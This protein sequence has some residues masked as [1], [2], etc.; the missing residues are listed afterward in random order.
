MPTQVKMKAERVQWVREN[1]RPANPLCSCGCGKKTK[2]GR[3]V[4]GHDAQLRSELETI[5]E[6]GG[7]SARPARE[8]LKRFGW[9]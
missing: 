4:P 9:L 1:A 6:A 8:A 3:F 2:G 7:P 5:V